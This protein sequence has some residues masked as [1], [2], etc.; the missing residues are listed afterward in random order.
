ML[1]TAAPWTSPWLSPGYEQ[2]FWDA[3]LDA[4]ADEVT[5]VMGPGG[6]VRLDRASHAKDLLGQLE[7]AWPIVASVVGVI[8]TGITALWARRKRARAPVTVHELEKLADQLAKDVENQ[9][10]RGATERGLLRPMPIPVRWQ[11]PKASIAVR[12]ADAV[13]S[14]QFEPLPGLAAME[15][16]RLKEG[17]LD[18]LH[19][20]YGGLTSGRLVIAGAPGSGKS[21]AAVLLILAALRYRR[22]SVSETDRPQVP[23][24]VM[25]TL[26]GWDPVT[27]PTEV[28]LAERLRQ[29]YYPLF[30][31]RRGIRI[32]RDMLT[33][34]RIAV[35]LDGLDEI[36][37]DLQPVALE[38]LSQ[39]A[40]FR[41][42]L[43]TRSDEIA[44]AAANALLLDA[45]AIELQDIDADSAAAYL[46]STQPDS[47][48]QGWQKLISRLRQKPGSPVAQALNSPLMLTLV[49][50]TYR[51]RDDPG[52]LLR[53]RNAAGRPAS[54]NVIADHILDRVL[55]AAYT[56]R[57]GEP[58]PRYSLQIAQDAL[59]RIATR[60]DKDGIR[61][62]QWWHIPAWGQAAARAITTGL[63]AGLM[64]GPLASLGAKHVF[65]PYLPPLQLLLFGVGAGVLVGLV[66]GTGV[67]SVASRFKSP[68]R[69]AQHWW[70]H[71]FRRR[72][73]RTG[74]AFG[75][76]I[77]LLAGLTIGL[78]MGLGL[79]TDGYGSPMDGLV[80]GLVAGL[81]TGLVTGLVTGIIAWLVTGIIRPETDTA[82]PLDPLASWRSDRAFGFV[83]TVVAALGIGLSVG[84]VAGLGPDL[85]IGLGGPGIG[86]RTAIVAGLIA[87]LEVGIMVWPSS[88]YTWSSSFAFA[89]IARSYRTPVRLMRFLE[90]ARSRNVLRTV[91]PIYQ[92]RHAR[93]QD[94]LA[95]RESAAATRPQ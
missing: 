58:E 22:E 26:Q 2:N 43:L 76:R 46:T 31:G 23:V 77:G 82:S 73:L 14:M 87:A 19:E 33:G 36:P 39:Q 6:V 32:A 63:V 69:I 94:R 11:R 29:T 8:G 47:P 15:E 86:A 35:L 51:P 91:G 66:T 74:L 25:F 55:P 64:A 24:P 90:D 34:G 28:W 92:F 17:Q 5:I 56:R 83:V 30:A 59:E 88:S 27:E 49:R 12:A 57:P 21:S 95:K 20:L 89:Q 80:T 85:L 48:S 18:D 42:V 44:T 4:A 65:R 61:D 3:A 1:A 79:A 38:A 71:A 45:M 7:K 40:T 52:E 37:E 9:W 60:M 81:K 50:D 10:I 75:L 78:G 72:A 13:A 53:R 41:L 16:E 67:F 70:R 68:R 84:L 93:L 54:A 62:L